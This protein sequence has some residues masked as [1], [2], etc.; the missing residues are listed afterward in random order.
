M[1]IKVNNKGVV[2]EEYVENGI[3]LRTRHGAVGNDLVNANKNMQWKLR[4]IHTK[5]FSVEDGE[6][7]CVDICTDSRIK[8]VLK[9][10]EC[11]KNMPMLE[12]HRGDLHIEITV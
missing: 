1:K 10:F 9:V 2:T 6:D 4:S 12:F 11:F 3:I 7:F 8:E 5:V